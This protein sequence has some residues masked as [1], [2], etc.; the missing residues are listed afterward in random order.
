MLATKDKPTIGQGLLVHDWPSPLHNAIK[1]LNIYR[2]AI[3][4]LHRETFTHDEFIVMLIL[5]AGID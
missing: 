4:I 3:L 2:Y 5:T 1:N